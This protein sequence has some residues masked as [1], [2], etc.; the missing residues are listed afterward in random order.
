MPGTPFSRRGTSEYPVSSPFIGQTHIYNHLREFLSE[1]ADAPI[2]NFIIYGDWGTGKSRVGHQL[3]AEGTN[4]EYGW[5]IEDE[6]G[7]YTEKHLFDEVDKEVLPL[8]VSLSEFENN[9][10][11]Q[12][13]GAK[14]VNAALANVAEIGSD[15]YSDIAN[16]FENAGGSLFE[17][18]DIAAN[19]GQPTQIL[20]QYLETVIEDS[21]IERL[22][23]IIDEVEEA[24]SIGDQAPDSEQTTGAGGQTLQALFE[25]L[26]EATNDVGGRY[27]A[28]FHADFTLLCTSGV[29]RHSAPTG[30]V[31]RRIE[32]ESLHDPTIRDAKEYVRRLLENAEAETEISSDAVEA[33]FFASF[34]NFGWFTR[35]MSTLHH[36][37]QQ[38]PDKAYYEIIKENPDRFDDIFDPQNVED[39]LGESDDFEIVNDVV[40][41]IYRI[42]PVAVEELDLS[43][44]EIDS[45]LDYTT[46]L[47]DIR[48]IGEL[49][50]VDTSN[51]SIKRELRKSG[52][53]VSP[54]ETSEQVV[55]YSG[56]RLKTGR[57]ED[58][59][60]VFQIGDDHIGLYDQ[61]EDLR[62]LAEFA[63]EAGQVE[64]AAIEALIDAL[65]AAREDNLT[66][67]GRYLAPTLRFLS[68]W[69]IRWRKYTQAVR[70]LDDEELWDELME[71]ARN[72]SDETE[73]VIK[74]FIYTRFHHYDDLSPPSLE[75]HDEGLPAT[76]FVT[77]IEGD[78]TVD[79]GRSDT[80]VV[81]HHEDTTDTKNSIRRIK[82][83]AT[84]G[85]PIIYLLFET[86]ST[87]QEVMAEVFDEYESITPFIISQVI[88]NRNLARDFFVQF[89]F[90]GNVFSSDDLRG[91]KN[92]IKENRVR[93][94]IHRDVEWFEE[95]K[96]EGWVLQELV[97][98][99]ASAEQKQI[100]AE[101]LRLAADGQ[102]LEQEHIDPWHRCWENSDRVAPLLSEDRQL[103]LPPFVPH[104]L[105]VIENE[106]PLQSTELAGRLLTDS[107]MQIETVTSNALELLSYLGLISEGDDGYLFHNSVL[108]DNRIE[109]VS[110]KVPS[111]TDD[112]FEDFEVEPTEQT[113]FD[114]RITD[115]NL[116]TYRGELEGLSSEIRDLNHEMI[117]NPESDPE[118]WYDT[119]SIIHRIVTFANRGYDP[120]K[121]F[122]SLENHSYEDIGNEYASMRDDTDHVEYSISYRFEF[123]EGF[124]DVLAQDRNSVLS[125]VNTRQQALYNHYDECR[126]KDF[127]TGKIASILSEIEADLELDA[128]SVDES[129]TQSD[130]DEEG[131]GNTIKH[132]LN[133]QEFEEAFTRI[134]WYKG[135]LQERLDGPWNDFTSAAYEFETFLDE[136]DELDESWNETDK[137][138]EG[139]THFENFLS[140]ENVPLFANIGSVPD[141]AELVDNN[142]SVNDVYDGL[143][144]DEEIN[145]SA[146]FDVIERVEEEPEERLGDAKPAVLLDSIKDLRRKVA[147]LDLHQKVAEEIADHKI[148][149]ELDGLEKE[150]APLEELSSAVD[151]EIDID[152][153]SIDGPNAFEDKSYGE[154]KELIT[155]IRDQIEDEGKRILNTVD[156]HGERYWESFITA[157]EAA[158]NNKAL[159]NS[160][161]DPDHL[162]K[163]SDW[164]IIQYEEQYYVSR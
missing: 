80:A 134:G 144:A 76:N 100:L 83:E 119:T 8:W 28:N 21:E 66:G 93:P 20:E 74:G 135:V 91:N 1:D 2:G 30:G 97:P 110:I 38:S 112:A 70:W 106:G 73:R 147:S 68:E 13:A 37:K 87:R 33:L 157:Y 65:E 140:N 81:F 105:S 14:A 95:Q 123:L 130:Q 56:T 124:D 54:A 159:S 125:E 27:P 11:T 142:T 111:S 85:F 24:G 158:E 4:I 18:E 129:L 99:Q 138:F 116:T 7:S 155:D 127:P 10:T 6:S 133:N 62:G 89:S 126:E 79:V 90:L 64:D 153:S 47:E 163:L 25:G 104:M 120:N 113:L 139:V 118:E 23:V 164:D 61:R 102:N 39:I 36:F 12:N 19:P 35:A 48:P 84:Q 31:E 103:R 148:Q 108:L 122:E 42:H 77:S 121:T 44:D 162:E 63:F 154:I 156:T 53:E 71:S 34:N 128:D 109:E 45:F 41:I 9:L 60:T 58:L 96:S 114:L 49:V 69:N 51:S 15:L 88:N 46:P 22:L 40:D 72:V 107:E 98:P 149:Q 32:E 43:A 75:P 101:G 143:D 161:I 5:L 55:T 52:F 132:H 160:D 50:P 59:L 136:F 86:E 67:D 82:R 145:P 17:L 115:S 150:W 57:L 26:K 3:V 151:E 92:Y 78:N 117:L 131:T 29:E 146:E 152:R 94:R 141:A 137:F 16:R